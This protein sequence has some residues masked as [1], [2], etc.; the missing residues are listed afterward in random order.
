MFAYLAA[1]EQKLLLSRKPR[2][3]CSV[4]P[5]NPRNKSYTISTTPLHSQNSRATVWFSSHTC[6]W[7]STIEVIFSIQ[8]DFHITNLYGFEGNFTKEAQLMRDRFEQRTNNA[9]ES[10]KQAMGEAS[11]ELYNCDPKKHVRGR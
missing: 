5:S 7:N 3:T 6:C 11:R 2:A 10:I 4:T 8:Y 1:S 9:I